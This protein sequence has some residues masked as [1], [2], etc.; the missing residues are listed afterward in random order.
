MRVTFLDVPR[1]TAS[2]GEDKSYDPYMRRVARYWG[3]GGIGDAILIETGPKNILID[4]GLWTK[5]REI[6]LPYLKKRGIKEL[7]TVIL[8]HQHGDHYG[9]LTEVLGEMPVKELITNGLTHTAK[10]YKKFM[11][12]AKSSGARYRVVKGGESM[13]WGGGVQAKVVQVGGRGIPAD[14]SNNSSVVVRM[15]CG[16]VHFLFTGDMEDDEEAAL[17]A[18]H[19]E[20]KSQI[21]KAGHHGSS[22]SSSYEFLRRVCP[23]VAVISIG[24]GNRFSL[25]HRSVIERFQSLG[26]T[27]YR[28][29]LDGTIVVASDGEKWTVETERKRPVAGAKGSPLSEKFYGFEDE[30][31]RLMRRR[32][33]AAAAEQFRKA[34]AL[35]PGAASAHSRLGYCYKKIGK[36]AEAIAAFHAALEQ[37]PCEPYANLHLGLIH[38]GDDRQRALGYLENYLKCH[39]TSRWSNLA[40]EKIGFIHSSRA[41]ELQRSGKEED[42]LDEYEKAIAVRRDLPVLHFRIGV[43][44]MS[45]DRDR[46]EKEFMKYL[47]LDPQGVHVTEARE[48]L[49][50]IRHSPARAESPSPM[51][52]AVE[53]E[54]GV[55]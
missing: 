53:E 9:G 30:A 42:A 11:D 20:I 10:A 50:A 19:Q 24:A 32:E 48:K 47:D 34:I 52:K 27:V 13:D 1:D 37:E 40:E 23:A 38:L 51:S 39:P 15:S 5:G 6:V 35:E 2:V 22:S 29:D 8:T 45:R 16:K 18:S 25:P 36:K 17:L 55:R 33:Y 31:V 21:L 4:G 12:A 44:Y 46:A 43:L 14:G 49:R 26:C 54:Q 28:T 7:D 41:E 3:Q